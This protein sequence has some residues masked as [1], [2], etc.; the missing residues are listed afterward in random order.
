MNVEYMF[1]RKLVWLSAI[2]IGIYVAYYL[3]NQ[4]SGIEKQRIAREQSD[5][6]KEETLKWSQKSQAIVKTINDDEP[7]KQYL[8][9][10]SVEEMESY[11]HSITV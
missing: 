9:E 5:K 8:L 11:Q 7:A 3:Y 4:K 10:P 1:W 6:E 2:L